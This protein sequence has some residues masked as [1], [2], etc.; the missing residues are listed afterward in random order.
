M[1]DIQFS[2]NDKGTSS[3]DMYGKNEISYGFKT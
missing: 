3:I 1:D 2:F